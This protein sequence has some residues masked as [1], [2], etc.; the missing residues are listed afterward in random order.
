[1]PL[2]A[3]YA[4][5]LVVLA[6]VAARALVTLRRARSDVTYLRVELH[7]LRQ[8]QGGTFGGAAVADG[9]II[10][11]ANPAFARM[12]GFDSTELIGTDAIE[13]AVPGFRAAVT[14]SLL[15]EPPE[16]QEIEGV[17]RDGTPI[18]LE[19]RGRV[20]VMDGRHVTIAEAR[21]ITKRKRAEEENR[22]LAAALEQA[23]EAVVIVGREGKVVYANAGFERISGYR[24]DEVQGQDWRMLA[25][26]T[27]GREAFAGILAAAQRGESWSGVFVQRRRDGSLYDAESVISPVRDAEGMVV[28]YLGIQRDVTRERELEKQLRQ[29]Q[30]L[31]AVGQLATGIVHDLN[32]MLSVIIANAEL[33]RESLP[34]DAPEAERDLDDLRGAARGGAAMVRKL[35]AFSRQADLTFTTVDLRQVIEDLSGMLRRILPENIEVRLAT[36]VPVQPVLADAGALQQIILNL[37][38]NARDAMPEGG[39]LDIALEAGT[40]DENLRGSHPWIRPGPC[41]AVVVTDTG[42]GM[43]EQTLERIFEPFFT[44]KPPGQGTGLGMAMIFGL[45]KQHAGIA[46]VTSRVGHGTTVRIL[47]PCAAPT[48]TAAPRRSSGSLALGGSETILLVEDNEALR[49]TGIRLLQKF[50]YRVL[51]AEDGQAALETFRDHREEIALV[52]SDLVMP[53]LGGQGLHAALRGLGSQVPFVFAS[54]YGEAVLHESV[55][56]DEGTFFAPKP[57]TPAELALK[58]REALD[59]G[60]A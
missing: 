51:P 41:T 21:D 6:V 29:A 57:W 16:P 28:N 58:V 44:T 2:S 24:R 42:T 49:R 3:L 46:D 23:A 11:D 14:R 18:V 8:L 30:K 34:A 9:G 39:V 48:D 43:D 5:S 1:M 27:H 13:R 38:T 50:G 25:S 31:E 33:L 26:P 17:R 59:T 20:A 22:R 56:M 32:N 19:V 12:F 60:R 45:A 7:R 35:L 4:L 36:A 47:L 40:L 53:R 10:L 54:G 37:A 15:D 55:P 52:I